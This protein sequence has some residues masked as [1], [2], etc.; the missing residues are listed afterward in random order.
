[1]LRGARFTLFLIS[2]DLLFYDGL[3]LARGRI[4][5]NRRLK[6]GETGAAEGKA[7]SDS[8]VEWRAQSRSRRPPKG[9]GAACLCGPNIFR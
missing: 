2:D 4:A 3:I 5:F 9:G 1:M 6:E 8:A 7:A